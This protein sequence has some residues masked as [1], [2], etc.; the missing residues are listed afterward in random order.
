MPAFPEFDPGRKILSH[1]QVDRWILAEHGAGRRVGFTCGSFDMLHPGHVQYLAAA[2]SRCDRLLVAVNSDA[3]VGRYKSP[4][5]PVN[6]ERE[7][8]YVV[9]GLAS[10]DAVTLLEDD[11]PLNLLLRWK[12][13]LYIKGGD[14]QSSGMRSAAAVE[15]YGG[16]VLA[17]PSDF[18][19]S[20][21]GLIARVSATLAHA[22][23]ERPPAATPRGL[24]LLDRDGTL[25]RDIPYLADPAGVELLPGVGEGLAELHGAG[26][27]LAIV[28]NQ[29]GIGLGYCSTGQMIAVNQR[30]FE[31]L[32]RYGVRISRVFYCPHSADDRCS[33]RKPLGGL[34]ERA[35]RELRMEARR[36]FLVGDRPSD[37]AA[38][39]SAGCRTV[40][41]GTAGD[42]DFR[43]EDVRAAASWIL[44]QPA[45]SSPADV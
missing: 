42:C 1:E 19:T 44:A 5:R 22:E 27:R 12:P 28:T 37:A 4:L 41:L 16:S 31:T 24:V 18:A 33:C 36:T 40:L 45:A 8:L 11:R 43:A 39:R 32:S 13:D 9:A 3:S 20:T 35:L 6:P 15:A 23:P 26:F 14:Y 25:I 38:G 21:S 30:L 34:V 29:Q 2:R 7:R 17:I 10:V